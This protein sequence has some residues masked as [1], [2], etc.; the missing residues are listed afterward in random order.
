MHKYLFYGVLIAG[1]SYSVYA[2]TLATIDCGSLI[3]TGSV[4]I[5]DT[6]LVKFTCPHINGEL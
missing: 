5:G 3:G 2:T 1:I 4:N 6:Y